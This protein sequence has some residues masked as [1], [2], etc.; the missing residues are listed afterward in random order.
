MAN[1]LARKTFTYSLSPVIDIVA[2]TNWKIKVNATLKKL[3]NNHSSSLTR[4]NVSSMHTSAADSLVEL[5]K[6]FSLFEK[7]EKWSHSAKIERATADENGVIQNSRDFG[8]HCSD[9][10]CSKWNLNFL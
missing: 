10:F 7:P 6:F 2:K 5:V 3:K 4:S 8:E 1:L 9:V